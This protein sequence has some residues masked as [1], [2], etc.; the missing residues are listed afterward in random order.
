VDMGIIDN[1]PGKR[2]NITDPFNNYKGKVSIKVQGSS[3]VGWPKRSFRITTL[4]AMNVGT[5]VSLLGMPPHEDWVLKA[6]Y[7][8]KSFLR[9]DLGH[10]IFRDMGHY[11]SR[12]RFFEMVIDGEYR[13]V[14]QLL[15]KVKRDRGRVSISK[16]TQA[17][18]SGDDL[19]GGYIISLDK[20][21]PGVDKGWHSKYK[22]NATGDS[23]NFYLYIYP[24]PDSIM[25]QQMNYIKN[26]V[27]QF[28]DAMMAPDLSK[29]NYQR[30]I[31]VPSFADNFILTELCRNVDGYRSSTFFHKDKASSGNGKLKAGPG[32]DF[33]IAFGNC[34]PNFGSDPYWWAYDQNTNVNFIPFWWK[35]LMSDSLF[36]NE[37]RCRYQKHRA[38]VLSEAHLF[39]YIDQMA[40]H[41]EEAQVRNYQRHPILGQVIWPGPS[42]APATYAGEIGYLKW[43][44]HERL[45]WM[46]KQLAGTCVVTVA[47]N[48]PANVQL[49]SGPNPFGES[50]ELSYHT[51]DNTFVKAELLGV[52][53]TRAMLISEGTKNEGLHQETISTSQIPVGPYILKLTMNNEV[54][55]QKLLK[56]NNN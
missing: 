54:Y 19:T 37:L 26:Y 5:D 23:A 13:G 47:S 25:P 52:M 48:D 10:K 18:V 21:V 15:E 12:S 41:L 33:N 32:W 53:G 43:W 31:D 55:Y 40:A 14:Y 38:G 36:K 56:I 4:N 20:F 51:A 45:L 46:D 35:K 11:S 7:Q 24:N 39:S 1:G 42:P 8:D 9:D 50:F 3:S 28:E 29:S 22:S 2:N 44:L 49:R 6:L 30:F 27:D 34:L 16:M 17:D